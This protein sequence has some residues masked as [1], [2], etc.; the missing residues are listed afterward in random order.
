[1]NWLYAI[2]GSPVSSKPAEGNRADYN[3]WLGK[4]NVD[5]TLD[6]MWWNEA[7]AHEAKH[8]QQYRENPIKSYLQSALANIN[9][10]LGNEDKYWYAPHEIEARQAG[11]NYLKDM[12]QSDRLEQRRANAMQD[13]YGQ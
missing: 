12:W 1:M 8:R 3:P 7:Y 5:P 10:N 9:L 4:I 6:P 11:T 2:M 13:I